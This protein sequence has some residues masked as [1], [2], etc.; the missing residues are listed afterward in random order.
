MALSPLC[1]ATFFPLFTFFSLFLPLSFLYLFLSHFS[2]TRNR[3][4]F[5]G[6]TRTNN[7]C[8]WAG[9]VT[10]KES[11]REREQG[12]EGKGGAGK[13]QQEK[14]FR[15]SQQN[16]KFKHLPQF[17]FGTLSLPSSPASFFDLAAFGAAT[18]A[19]YSLFLIRYSYY[20]T[21]THTHI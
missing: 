16:A 5:T 14:S 1:L 20:K 17:E 4:P 21:H 7:A 10:D 12:G 9:G 15:L 11:E 8:G 13:A 2:A 3:F 18:R 6:R 19:A